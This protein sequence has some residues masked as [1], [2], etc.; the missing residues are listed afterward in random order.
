MYTITKQFPRQVCLLVKSTELNQ[1][2][3]EKNYLALRPPHPFLHHSIRTN[4]PHPRKGN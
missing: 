4:I 2:K 1:D 3:R